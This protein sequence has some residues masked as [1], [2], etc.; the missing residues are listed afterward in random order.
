M[1]RVF[2]YFIFILPL[3]LLI[4]CQKNFPTQSEK[5]GLHSVQSMND[6]KVPANFNWKMT[7][8]LQVRIELPN[9]GDVKLLT[10]TSSNGNKKYF[11]GYPDDG[12]R[13]L[14]TRITVPSYVNMVQ[15]KYGNGSTYPPVNVGVDNTSLAYSFNGNLKNTN[16]PC[17]PCNGQVNFLELQ[18]LG[19][20]TNPVI[21]VTQ[22][23]GSNHHFVIYNNNVPQNGTFSFSGANNPNHK[24]GASIKVYINGV[25]NVSIHTSCS[26]TILAG[27]QFGDFLVV[28][29]TSVHGGQLCSI[30]GGNTPPIA[31]FTVTPSYGTTSTL[32][33]F[34]ASGVSDAEDATPLLEVRWDFDGNGTWDTPWTTIKTATHQYANEA[35]YA[36]KLEVKDTGGLND[37]AIGNIIVNNSGGGSTTVNYSGTLAYEDLWPS[38]GD[39]DFNDLV[40]GYNFLI[41]KNR[42]EQIMHITGTFTIYAFGASFYNGFG[43]TFPNVTPNQI[44][45][46]TGYELKPNSIHTMASNGLE[47]GQSK[48]TVIVYDDSFDQMTHPGIGTGVNT[49]LGAPYVTPKTLTI[50][51]SFMNGNVPAP[52]GAVTFNELNIGNFNPFIIVNQMRGTEVHLPDYLPSDLADPSQL[53]TFEDA[54]NPTTGKYYVTATN[55]PWAINIPAF[56]DYPIEKTDITQAYNH[57][58]EWA[59]SGGQQYQDWYENLPG[60]RNASFIY[61]H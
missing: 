7:N 53:G 17:A 38:K 32:F 18:Y 57:F 27:M 15:L 47:A 2:Q 9:K 48:A 12:S 24:M 29:G 59:E 26:Q 42:S 36:P 39:Y 6:L 35:T 54:S 28:S 20:D 4:S 8:T 43:F 3:L 41:T 31:T 40:I 49:E 14:K 60:Y 10:I 19:T 55:L 22:Q 56:F 58:A 5:K 46:V 61:T 16:T 44:I 37:V 52:G 51:M 33:T 21:Q 23:K 1:K 13:T 30:N 34:D 50:E 25:Q 45:S 11:S